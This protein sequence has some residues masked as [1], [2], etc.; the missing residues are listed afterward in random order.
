MPEPGRPRTNTTFGRL[1]LAN[2]LDKYKIFNVTFETKIKLT[3]VND[4]NYYI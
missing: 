1:I 3:D 4:N 2:I